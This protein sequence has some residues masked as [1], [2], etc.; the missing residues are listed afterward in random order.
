MRKMAAMPGCVPLAC[1]RK[2]VERILLGRRQ[3]VGLR[4]LTQ[5]DE[6]A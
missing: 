6:I 2:K 5:K 4:R 1:T 3:V